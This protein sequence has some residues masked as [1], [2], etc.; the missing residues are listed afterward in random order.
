MTVSLPEDVIDTLSQ[1]YHACVNSNSGPNGTNSNG[2]EGMVPVFFRGLNIESVLDESPLPD[3]KNVL[4]LAQT[5]PIE[6]ANFLLV[7]RKVLTRKAAFIMDFGFWMGM[8]MVA[9]LTEH[10]ARAL[11]GAV[12]ALQTKYRRSRDVISS[13]THYFRDGK[14]HFFRTR[15]TSGHHE[16][17]P[18]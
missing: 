5:Y 2:T 4:R 6:G 3:A 8:K 15:I 9:C 17:A 7:M 10:N 1:L 14:E 12:G 16:P 18:V 11:S 13:A